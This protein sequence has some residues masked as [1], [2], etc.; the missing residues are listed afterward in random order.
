MPVISEGDVV[1]RLPVGANGGDVGQ[2]D[3]RVRADRARGLREPIAQLRVQAA[4]EGD[5]GPFQRAAI[6]YALLQARGAG[7]QQV[8]D[9][10]ELAAFLRHNGGVTAIHGRAAD[11]A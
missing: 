4:G 5:V 2:G 7:M 8:V 10:T 6:Q 1:D 9:Q 3:A 11:E